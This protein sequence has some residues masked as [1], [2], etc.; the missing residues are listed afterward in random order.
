MPNY[1]LVYLSCST[2]R[3]ITVF[4]DKLDLI[5]LMIEFGLSFISSFEEYAKFD[6]ICFLAFHRSLDN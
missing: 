2:C 6:Y 5:K 1:R 3:L 4:L